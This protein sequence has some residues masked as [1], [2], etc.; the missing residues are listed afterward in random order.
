[1]P[2]IF[3]SYGIADEQQTPVAQTKPKDQ[4]ATAGDFVKELGASAVDAIGATGQGFGE[5]GAYVANKVT[6]TEAY[7]GKNLLN[8]A[9]KKIRD[10]MTEGGKQA[11]QEA[12]V[13]GSVVD[14]ING[15]AK[16][17]ST[18]R[19]W[20]MLGINGFGSMAPML[21]PGGAMASR[22]SSI[23][24][25]AKAAEA[26]GDAI[27]AAKLAKAASS[28]ANSAK[29]ISAVLSGSMTG[30]AAAEDVRDSARRTLD[31]M[32]HQELVEQI[33][34]YEEAFKKYG[35]EAEARD[36]VVNGAARW[37]AGL[38]AVAGAAGGAMNQKF[39]EDFMVKKGVAAVIGNNIASR[40][41]RAGVAGVGIGL[42]EGGQEVAEKVGQ[43]AGE[44]IGLG[45]T[46]GYDV[47]RDTAGDFLG[48]AM[49]G[50]GLGATGG[51]LTEYTP[52]AANDTSKVGEKAL[53]PDS[54]LSRAAV[55]S[56]P[57]LAPDPISVR[58]KEVEAAF[59]EG[60]LLDKL[61]EIGQGSLTRQEFLEALA[62]AKNPNQPPKFR[63]M[64]MDSVNQAM[65]WLAQGAMPNDPATGT[66]FSTDLTVQ[67]APATPGTGVA[68][69]AAGAVSNQGM[70]QLDPNT[71]DGDVTR[72]DN[73]IEGPRALPAPQARLENGTP[74]SEPNQ[75]P[76]PDKS[77]QAAINSVAPTQEEANGTQ[78][79]EA[80]QAATQ[81]QQESAPAVDPATPYA[82]PVAAE[83]QAPNVATPAGDGPAVR[84]K[85][86][87][88]LK[89]MAAAGFDTV[90]QRNGEF[91]MVNHARN[92]EMRLQ[93]MADSQIARKAIADQV[94]GQAATAAA[95]PNNDRKNPT[96]GQIAA[97]NY[98]KSDE[99]KINGMRVVLEN[100][101]HSTRSGVGADGKRWSTKMAHHY[102]EFLGTEGADG[103]RM[104][105]FIGP[106][107]DSDKVF[108][109]DQVNQDGTFDEHKVMMGFKDME[110]ARAGYMAN[111][112]A[113]WTG[114]GAI[115]EMPVSA[116]KA[117][118][119][120]PAA[121][122]PAAGYDQ[123]SLEG[124][125]NG[126]R[127][128]VDES[129][130]AA[131]AADPGVQTGG[132]ADQQAR[133]GAEN[134]SGGQDRGNQDAAQLAAVSALSQRLQ[135]PITLANGDSDAERSLGAL[136]DAFAKLTGVRGIA[137]K[138]AG[139]GANDGVYDGKNF[140]VNVDRP[141]MHVAQTI[142]HEFK[143]LSSSYPGI[144]KLFDRIWDLVDEGGRREYYQYL[145][146]TN[147]VTSDY[148]KAT[149]AELDLLK[150]EVVS[151][152][153]GKRMTDKAWLSD[154]AK[155]KPA[156]FA[157]FVRDWVKVLSQVIDSLKGL[158]KTMSG[159]KNV[160]K[161]IS[162]LEKAKAIAM[163]V[164]T[165]WAESHKSMAEKSGLA[166]A[167][168]LSARMDEIS[169]LGAFN[170]DA[171]NDYLDEQAAEQAEREAL[172]SELQSVTAQIDVKAAPMR[173]RKDVT[174]DEIAAA[175]IRAE[176]AYPALD[177]RPMMGSGALTIKIPN[178]FGDGVVSSI[179]LE[180]QP[181]DLYGVTARGTW[182]GPV[183]TEN[184]GYVT[185]GMAREF[186]KR[187]VAA[188]DLRAR[189]FD[190]S[191]VVDKSATIRI[192]DAWSKLN[193]L[194]GAKKYGSVGR[195]SASMS[196]IA[197]DLGITGGYEVN[198]RKDDL[199]NK[200]TQTF[201]EFKNKET[202]I[203]E[204]A[205]LDVFMESGKRVAVANTSYLNRNGLGSAVYQLFAEYS[206]RNG[207][208]L[209]PDGNVSGI[210]SYRRTE[211]MLSSA[212]R[213]GRSN[214][215]IPHYVQRLY[216]FNPDA[217]SET[218]HNKNI[219][220]MLLAGLRNVLEL[221]PQA[222]T[223]RYHP[224]TDAFTNSVGVPMDSE[225]DKFLANDVDARAL[226]LGRSTVA[227]AVLTRMA[228]DNEL[229]MPKTLKAPVL[230]S[231]RVKADAERDAVIAKYKGTP[232][233]KRAP[234]GKPTNLTERQW[235][236]V[237]TPSFK[238]WFGDWE[239]FAGMEGGV[240]NDAD[241]SVSKVVDDNGEPMVVY[242][243]TDNGGFFKFKQPGGQRRGDMGIFTSSDYG[244][245]RSYARKGRLQEMDVPTS[246]ADLEEMGYQF[247][248]GFFADG[249]YYSEEPE[250]GAPVVRVT[251]V[252]GYDFNSDDRE[253]GWHF[254]SKDDAVQ[255]ILD[256]MDQL[257]KRSVV[258]E[259]FLNLR[260][261]VEDNFEGANFSG[262]RLHQFVVVLEEGGDMQVRADGRQYLDEED[263]RKLADEIG[264]IVEQA[265]DHY[266]NTDTATREGWKNGHDGAIIR[267]VIDDG[268]GPGYDGDPADVFVAIDPAQFKSA[269]FN[270]GTFDKSD[271][272][273]FSKR[274][275]ASAL[276][277]SP[278]IK[279]IAKY[280]T[281]SEASKLAAGT[282]QKLA[283]IYKA[284]PSSDEVAAVAYAGRA[285]RGWYK[286]SYE[287]I[288]HIF[289]DEGWRFAALLAAT[290]PQCSVEVNLLNALNTW[291]NWNESGRPQ[292][293]DAIVQVMGRSV[294]GN[295]GVKSVLDAWVNNS[296]RALTAKS[297]AD[298]ALSGPKVDSFMRNLNG[299][300]MEVTNDAW[301]ANYALIS[302]K[303][304]SGKLLESTQDPGKGPGYLAMSA[305]VREAARKLGWTP[306]EVQET[307]WSWAMSLLE[308]MDR[309]GESRGAR[310]IMSDGSL[311]DDVINAT[312]D[313]RTLFHKPVYA[314]ILD[315][316]GYAGKLSSLQSTD[317]K[318]YTGKA[319]FDEA[320]TEK[321]LGTA[322][323]RLEF[324]Q[325]QRRTNVQLSWEARP[326][327]STGI[328]PGIH[329]A[330]EALQHEY[331]TEIFSAIRES[332]L[333]KKI[334]MSLK[335][336]LFGSGAWQ[337]EI[338]AG[339]QS[340][341]R[342]GVEGDGTGGVVVDKKTRDKLELAA[343][344]L[345]LVLNQEGVYWH[346]PVYRGIPELENGVEADF[347]R[348]L[349]SKEMERLYKIIIRKAGREDWAPA[350]TP[351][352]VRVLNFSNTSNK[353]FQRLVKSAITEFSRK[354][355]TGVDIG[356]FSA[357]GDAIENDWTENKNG[358]GYRSR[359]A[360][361]KS[362][363]L[364]GW[365]DSKLQ[366]DIDEVNRRFSEKY[367]WGRAVR[368]SARTPGLQGPEGDARGGAGGRSIPPGSAQSSFEKDRLAPLP[369]APVVPGFHGPDPQ[370]VAVA[371]R[372]ARNIGI[373]LQRQ[374][375]YVDIDPERAAL[376]AAEYEK[377]EHAPSDPAVKEAYE[378]LIKQTVAQY[379]ALVDAGY[380]FWFIDLSKESNQE[381]A[382]TPWNAMRDVRANKQM[383]VFPTA[384]GFG[385]S[386]EV[387][388]KD[389]PLE[390]PT[391]FK[392][393]KGGLDGPLET[394]Y[395]NDLFRAVHDAFGH[396]LEGSGFRARGEENAWQAHVRLFTGSAVGA[397]TSE[398]RGQNSW[399]NYGP[400]GEAN[401]NAK[402]ED[403]RFADQKTGLM[404]D[405]TWTAGRAGD[406]RLSARS[407]L[408]FYSELSTKIQAASMNQAPAGAWKSYI[409]AL[410]QKGVKKDEIEWSGV[411]DWLDLKDGKVAKADLLAY[412]DANGVQVEEI[413][414]SESGFDYQDLSVQ[415]TGFGDY[416]IV[417]NETDEYVGGT[418]PTRREAREAADEM[419]NNKPTKYAQYALPGGENY[420]ELLLRL[421][422]RE[423]D[424]SVDDLIDEMVK[425]YG[426]A[427]IYDQI[428]DNYF[429][430]KDSFPG[431]LSEE[432]QAR[433]AAAVNSSRKE[434]RPYRSGHWDDSNILAHIRIDDRID[435]D[436]KKVLFV[437][438]LQSD[439][440]Q[441]GK[442]KGFKQEI[443]RNAIESRVQA[444]T[445]RLREIAKSGAEGDPVLE[446]EW[447]KLSEEKSGLTEQLVRNMH[448]VPSGPFVTKTDGWLSLGLKRVI[449]LA[450]DGG[451]DK[452][453][454][455]NGKQ[456]AD[457][458]DLSK[459][460]DK[461][462]WDEDTKRLTAW[463]GRNPVID[464][465]NVTADRLED[466]VG[467]EVARK[468]IDQE[469]DE[470]G[471]RT[472]KGLDLK[473]GGEGMIAFYDTIVPN[474][475]KAML[476]KVGGGSLGLI[477]VTPE[478]QRF[479][480]GVSGVDIMQWKGIPREEHSSYWGGLSQEE[481]DSLVEE[482]RNRKGERMIQQGF[483]VTPE[484]RAKVASGLPLFSKRNPGDAEGSKSII[485]AEPTA[486]DFGRRMRN[487]RE[488]LACL[489]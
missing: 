283:A 160:D 435:P 59:R 473:V 224:E 25:A 386:D 246:L 161:Y 166:E 372:Y 465:S 88:Q 468:L 389:N 405:W 422:D 207:I 416:G 74:V 272:I 1:M 62:I 167:M 80:Q 190:L 320:K 174:A 102:G 181:D 335:N 486:D 472:L 295:K 42:S 273:R 255:Y 184:T 450:A 296:V 466:F 182:I 194:D 300:T 205:I 481:R 323:D 271:D 408:G 397:I 49:A 189:K 183:N 476:K 360:G 427:A 139:D 421:P 456:S 86:A 10:S 191:S 328:L 58:V 16:L 373:D 459:Q 411:N 258:Y 241:N 26:A 169:D 220:I 252:D 73:M 348:S 396:G 68:T 294:Q 298:I 384:D 100:P 18:A 152:F 378:N 286:G 204:A 120:S 79:P 359:I 409:A 412:L 164:A 83:V 98:K 326:G 93:G 81:G 37:A 290:S 92:E 132:D 250:D 48:G 123:R 399:L 334:G 403:T 69:R 78:A 467:K 454:F 375:Q 150:D 288:N 163:E 377:M 385:S 428:D 293:E 106:R 219:S 235:I 262:E 2:S 19:G 121:A 147:Q 349:S 230:Y 118:A 392:W 13:E 202:G 369:G 282:A 301:M 429:S 303:M 170:L 446:A 236:Q 270:V 319:P 11:R 242:H 451:Y 355:K 292:S 406:L 122:S 142:G 332:G 285:K 336:T 280:L 43:N 420:R 376:I 23:S 394:V 9:S 415:N 338:S 197:E 217:R 7:E 318:P 32:S 354:L 325:R 305:K 314:A 141:H 115:T 462:D 343:S 317:A 151:D 347:G 444:I 64:A 284:L 442:K 214:V 144:Q 311:S 213:T 289:G 233:W 14:L 434:R 480:G 469:A 210:N 40:A 117:W 203:M 278:A 329:E 129:A 31:L 196:D 222:E 308:M 304:F 24:K 177:F 307:V 362:S 417:N 200:H 245:A 30:G 321:L 382:S 437:E 54:V 143:H 35:N 135:E 379:Q 112:E 316:A 276:A 398:T 232:D 249:E 172:R 34:A 33:P 3:E 350:N 231:A 195:G 363:D 424:F 264:G 244:L 457:R 287:A 45:N 237:R 107:P 419:L 148:D 216:G 324:L 209:K 105:V 438:E 458:Y 198:I 291:K 215:M 175:G 67:P 479:T 266:Q 257:D 38:S 337:G 254:K 63:Q 312:P 306:A 188:S 5:I 131:G 65:E 221:M 453:A 460:I 137:I 471:T 275:P 448:G 436:G 240:W 413:A 149:S 119:K 341:T 227:R 89:A 130:A 381:Y 474:A 449:A 50:G 84:R 443:D 156:L 484:M 159:V 138:W 55:A 432:D 206:A 22:V 95:S 391:E 223:L 57:G 208:T 17:P 251:D 387:E 357:D 418:Y 279:N 192:L 28:A 260:N 423:P 99:I 101:R 353:D 327:R 53:E 361:S 470:D 351:I 368:L 253:L 274:V 487:M 461:L 478:K 158:V 66:P 39:L 178:Q 339:A 330:P 226:G 218:E 185:E 168:R 309:K 90:E 342:P 20:A 261:P 211:Q 51:A 485:D 21:L 176:D 322:G 41:G 12:A 482:Y 234:N 52:P 72:V 393:P 447:S 345:G 445:A 475:V 71:I 367:G 390:A 229:E 364:L 225:I 70:W 256:N 400:F 154:L 109:I 407:P 302:Q 128:R 126:E 315:A 313:F 36:A 110:S 76:A 247:E 94:E 340:I 44:N 433:Y 75:A 395:A 61:G 199:G 153:M 268:G 281:D 46:A 414:L 431:M 243:G 374:D 269:E 352:G 439:W 441:D 97:G 310:Q 134:S 464:E 239:K 365:I 108:V 383:G 155:R 410:T 193:N 201:V 401:R 404:P 186:G 299:D 248:D 265:P 402:V 125:Q 356:Y 29:A 366:A 297:F 165:V 440:G 430:I 212:M 425:K 380:K 82:T 145:K 228:M 187:L 488:L 136:L 358:Q 388:F 371:E 238:E 127:K 179:T 111:Y 180:P 483:D 267:E 85:R 87:A 116:F 331:L 15:D 259:A 162:E 6:G 171:A 426:K 157:D 113:G 146:D 477:D 77:A 8:P 114:L 346:Y 60:G 489:G 124:A 47:L 140:F 104:D 133:G 263:A 173:A 333:E 344:V 370:L 277:A 56:N 96:D 4:S 103:D 463:N 452:V 455:V 91:W 27:Q